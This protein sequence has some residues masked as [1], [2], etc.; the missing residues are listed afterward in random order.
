MR[1][2]IAIAIG[3]LTL[4][5]GTAWAQTRPESSADVSAG[6]RFLQSNGT[7]YPA[8]WYVDWTR[9]VNR[10]SGRPSLVPPI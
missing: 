1:R 5:S 3:M 9:H 2:L 8:G 7:S 4:T 6:Y 10:R